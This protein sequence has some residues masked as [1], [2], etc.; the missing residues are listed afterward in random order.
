MHTKIKRLVTPLGGLLIITATA[1]AAH[2]QSATSGGYGATTFCCSSSGTDDN[3]DFY[4]ISCTV[5]PFS[6]S[7]INQC[8]N[9]SFSCGIDSEVYCYPSGTTGYSQE[10]QDCSCF[11]FSFAEE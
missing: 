9:T 6:P 8:Q 5:A 10:L 4:G 2:A 11:S 3:S 1:V 7:V